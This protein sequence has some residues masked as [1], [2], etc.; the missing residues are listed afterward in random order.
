[1]Y[2]LSAPKRRT[3]LS[4]SEFSWSPAAEPAVETNSEY[5]VPQ[6][7]E[8]ETECGQGRRNTS[9]YLKHSAAQTEMSTVY[10]CDIQQQVLSEARYT[11]F[12]ILTRSVRPLHAEMRRHDPGS[13]LLAR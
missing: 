9:A 13:R 10:V 5:I 1:M 2:V 8:V 11:E 7:V 4:F 6:S 3:K 12:D